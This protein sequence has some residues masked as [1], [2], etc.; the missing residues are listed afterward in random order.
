MKIVK[1]PLKTTWDKQWKHYNRAP[2]FKP[3]HK[4]IQEIVQ[5][6]DGDVKNKKILEIGA[7]SGCDILCLS[8]MGARGYALDF[9]SESIK[10]IQYWSKKTDTAIHIKQA[11]ILHLPY[12]KPQFDMVYSVG[13]M[14]H[15]EDPI[16][17]LK[18]QVSIIKKG[19]F[20]LVDVPQKY[21][22]YTIAKHVRMS[23]GTH[24][25]GWETEYS[26]GDL[27]KISEK[28]HTKIVRFYGRDLDIIQKIPIQIRPHI[29]TFYKKM[30]ENTFISP[31][32]GLSIG[33][34]MKVR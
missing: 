30:V 15:F 5:C 28:L 25:F 4:V 16:P 23:F 33:M 2:F 24:P 27:R 31:Y 26:L 7:G 19:G 17:L 13:L 3:N 11:D 20:L 22:L 32:I 14:E 10:T 12:T 18:Q 21:S 9:S 1:Y 6:F 29:N 34:V 8:K